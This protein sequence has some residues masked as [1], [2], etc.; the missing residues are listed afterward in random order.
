MQKIFTS[1]FLLFLGLALLISCKGNQTTTSKKEEDSNSKPYWLSGAGFDEGYYIGVG[2]SLKNDGN[3]VQ[4]AKDN[5]LQALISEIKVQVS[6]SSIL[7]QVDKNNEF[8]EEYESQ[9]KTSAAEEIQDF[10]LAGTWEEGNGYW[11]Y[12]RLS[13]S[14]YAMLKEQQRQDATDLSMQMRRRA[15]QSQKEGDIAHALSFYAKSFKALEKFLGEPTRV[16]IDGNTVFL[17]VDLFSSV[18]DLMNDLKVSTP[19]NKIE[20]DR[21]LTGGLKVP[22]TVTNA[23]TGKIEVGIPIRASFSVGGGDVHPSYY[24][25]EEGKVVVLVSRI[26]SRNALQKLKIAVDPSVFLGEGEHQLSVKILQ[27]LVQPKEFV[28]ITV[29]KPTI[30]FR[31]TETVMGKKNDA[32]SYTPII[33]S[34]LTKAGFSLRDSKG[35]S[36][37]SMVISGNLEKGPK[38]GTTCITYSNLQIEVLDS[39]SSEQIYQGGFSKIKGFSNDY[40]R[41]ARYAYNEGKKLLEEE[42]LKELLNAILQ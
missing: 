14:R 29:K 42:K 21:R 19:V 40:E 26:D 4:I 38:S 10:E 6:S 11:V 12:Y 32:M 27:S 17:G 34:A 18:Q 28:E 1:N 8:R 37:L 33:K 41:S 25:N 30:Y 2:Y 20:T 22:A 23:K 5:A 3:Y 13:K 15:I 35:D 9:V 39:E 16:E 31:S 7:T 24:S 36:D